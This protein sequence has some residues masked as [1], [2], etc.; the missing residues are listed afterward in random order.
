MLLVCAAPAHGKVIGSGSGTSFANASGKAKEPKRLA[1]AI[2]TSAITPQSV[3]VSYGVSCSARRF[4]F[5]FTQGTFVATT[6]AN[7]R[8]P[9]PLK[10]PQK[11]NVT[12]SASQSDFFMPQFVISIEIT[13]RRR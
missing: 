9:I 12:V 6:P 4:K 2:N 11:C 8:L 7:R 10:R 13:A 1:V 5:D 3:D